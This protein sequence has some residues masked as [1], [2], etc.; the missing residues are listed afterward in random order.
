VSIWDFVEER[1]RLGSF[2]SG[3]GLGSEFTV[4]AP[5][6]RA[7]LV[8]DR[9]FSAEILA[10]AKLAKHHPERAAADPIAFALPFFT[11]P[12]RLA[13]VLSCVLDEPIDPRACKIPE[14]VEAI[15]RASFRNVDGPRFFEA[16]ALDSAVSRA[17]GTG[18][19]ASAPTEEE[20]ADVLEKA[21]VALSRMYGVLPAK[22]L[23]LPFLAFQSM[24][25]NS[26]LGSGAGDSADGD[27]SGIASPAELEASGLFAVE[28]TT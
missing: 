26:S 25:R 2:G 16:L 18:V 27:S 8:A 17:D 20:T 15:V 5:T 11:D 12:T 1:Y 23:D 24:I 4:R 21:V 28:A 10:V 19:E 22:I 6:L 14:V 9:D 13:L 3:S 7:V